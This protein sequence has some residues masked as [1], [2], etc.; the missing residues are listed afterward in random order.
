MIAPGLRVAG[1]ADD[2][3]VEAV[4]M[5]ERRFVLGVQWHPEQ[6]GA[7]LRLFEA[8]VAAAA[9]TVEERKG[10]RGEHLRV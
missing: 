6:D 9:N 8:L 3:T 5:P 1:V 10:A 4:E 7:D 2:G